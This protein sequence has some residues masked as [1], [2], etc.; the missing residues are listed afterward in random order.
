M[1]YKAAMRFNIIFLLAFLLIN[2]FIQRNDNKQYSPPPK[3]KLPIKTKTSFNKKHDFYFYRSVLT[4]QKWGLDKELKRKLTHLNLLHLMTPSGLHLSSLFLIFYFLRRRYPRL[5]NLVELT[6]CLGFYF[7]LP[8]YYSFRRVA[9]IRSFFILNK[10]RETNY[11]KMQIFIFFLVTDFFFGTY[12]YSPLSFYLSTLFLGLIFS[13]KEYRI[14]K[15][16]LLFFVAQLFIAHKFTGV[17]YPATIILSPLL[18][19]IFTLIYP[20]LFFNLFFIEYFNYAQWFISAYT[21]LIKLSYDLAQALGFI[22]INFLILI[23]VII[24][25]QK[26][27]KHALALI[28]IGL[29]S[30]F[31]RDSLAILLSEIGVGL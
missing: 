10:T 26:T 17:I 8:G 11:S 25:S 21:E 27:R 12:R 24:Y 16:Y 4:G 29:V 15:M 9:L 28:T 30:N 18:T 19:S 13:I 31:P 20:I 1:T 7:F 5:S 23:G 3:L 2:P 14:Y 22:H 6:L